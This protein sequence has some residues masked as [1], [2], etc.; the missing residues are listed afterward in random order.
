MMKQAKKQKKQKNISDR[1]MW[2][3]YIQHVTDTI[4]VLVECAIHTQNMQEKLLKIDGC[5]LA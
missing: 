5:Y 1:Y 4:L 3:I 2:Y